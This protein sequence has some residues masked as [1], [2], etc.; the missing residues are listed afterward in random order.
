MGR[1]SVTPSI[2]PRM[3]T[4]SQ[5]GTE[6]SAHDLFAAV[7]SDHVAGEPVRVG[8]AQDDDRAGHVV[9]GGQP[10]MRI[11]PR[12]LLGEFLEVGDLLGR[13]GRGHRGA[14]EVAGYAV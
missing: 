11:A 13:G 5:S 3:T 9:G 1:N 8:V 14:D 4:A 12:R 10:A 2:T 7:D 6:A